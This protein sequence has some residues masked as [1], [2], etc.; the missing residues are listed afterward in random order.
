MCRGVGLLFPRFGVQS[1]QSTK[2]WI[3]DSPYSTS[4]ATTP[5]TNV[6]VHPPA[7]AYPQQ[8][9][10]PP[11]HLTISL[12][13]LLGGATSPELLLSPTI[14][15]ASPDPQFLLSLRWAQAGAILPRIIFGW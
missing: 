3:I 13:C 2:D 11:E 10:S 7:P 15:I 6:G 1:P 12:Y 9:F 5:V 4:Q 14:R 8:D